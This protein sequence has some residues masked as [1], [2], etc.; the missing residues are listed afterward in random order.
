MND[1]TVFSNERFGRIRTVLIDGVVWFVGKDVAAALGYSNPRKALADHVEK[2]DKICGVT[3]RDPMG[4]EQKPTLI[5]ESGVYSLIFASKL[6]DAKEFKHWIIDDIT[7]TGR[8]LT[9]AV[10]SDNSLQTFDYHSGK[11]RTVTIDGEPWF[12][13]KDVCDI[14]ELT[15][16]AR[17]AERLDTDEVSLTHLTDSLGRKQTI[18]IINESGLYH[19]VLRSDKPEAKPFRKWITADV[20]PTLRK[21]GSY[22]TGVQIDT[23]KQQRA[24]AMLNNSR[25]RVA[26][27]WLKISDMTTPE[28]RQV[29][30]S[31][32][33]AALCGKEVIPLPTAVSEHL[34]TAEEVGGELGLS[35]NKVGRL[36]NELGLKTAQYGKFFYDKAKNCNKEVQTF[37]YNQLAVDALRIFQAG[38]GATF[39]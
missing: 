22:S 26:S 1:L 27:L 28:Y 34:Y 15:T 21:T 16:P 38:G 30:S 33:S 10:E 2:I 25:A 32:A 35:A 37:K 23:A 20:L 36:A 31:Y 29:C 12:V 7:H 6:P 13:L 8:C 9:N 4:R 3:I 11:V 24:E 18:T 39:L 14:L 17:V 19:V 5:N